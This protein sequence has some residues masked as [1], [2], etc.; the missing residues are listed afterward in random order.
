[1]KRTS[2]ILSALLLSSMAATSASAQRRS[3]VVRGNQPENS[4][5][6]NATPRAGAELPPRENSGSV[7]NS[8]RI[9]AFSETASIDE[10]QETEAIS[11]LCAAYDE[12]GSAHDECWDVFTAMDADSD[13]LITNAEA[14]E[15]YGDILI[16][17][18]PLEFD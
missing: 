6:E 17:G 1:M 4:A 2:I 11:D 18:V 15:K 3:N 5:N 9:E 16:D 10:E 14:T 7:G 8:I 12:G 13:G